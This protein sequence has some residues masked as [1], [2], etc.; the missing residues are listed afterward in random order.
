VKLPGPDLIGIAYGCSEVALSIFKRSRGA[1]V[2]ADRGSL[3]LLWMTILASVVVAVL[4]PAMLPAAH[5]N[6][7]EALYP[8]GLVIFVLGLALRWW[9]I[10]HLGR[11]FTV[12]VAIAADHRVV[13]TGPYRR[14]RHPSYAGAILAFVGYGMCLCN[15]ASLAALT[16]PV[17]LAFVVRIK[18]EE[19][20]LRA[21]LGAPYAEYAS[22]TKRLVPFV[23]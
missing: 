17:T 4:A 5:S 20:A 14:I 19:A 15:W 2:R 7:L 18:V 8:V 9:A 22:R 13:D 16:V 23:Y 11:F 12:D 21:S 3:R 10:V 6:W 1:A